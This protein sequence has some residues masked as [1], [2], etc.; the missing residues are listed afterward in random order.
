MVV[1][2]TLRSIEQLTHFERANILYKTAPPIP[3][4]TNTCSRDVFSIC[5]LHFPLAQYA[6]YKASVLLPHDLHHFV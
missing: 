2:G 1:I 5:K 3:L 4:N 6:L